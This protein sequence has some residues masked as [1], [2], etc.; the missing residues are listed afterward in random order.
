MR[1]AAFDFQIAGMT[2]LTSP[3]SAMPIDHIGQRLRTILRE[4]QQIQAIN[5]I[6]GVGELTASALVAAVGDFG[7]FKSGRQF[8]SWVV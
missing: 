8:A 3:L 2:I 7:T 4:D 6:P 1:R 5:Q